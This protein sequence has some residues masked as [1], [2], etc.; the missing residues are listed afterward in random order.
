M[1]YTPTRPVDQGDRIRL[2]PSPDAARAE[3]G[4]DRPIF[5]VAVRLESRQ[6]RVVPLW[7]LPQAFDPTWTTPAQIHADGSVT[8]RAPIPRPLFVG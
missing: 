6:R 7:T 8:A 4:S 3:A 5:E 2:Y 1:L